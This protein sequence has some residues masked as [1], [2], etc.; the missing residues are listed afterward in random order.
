M[1]KILSLEEL[2]CT[3]CGQGFSYDRKEILNTI[4]DFINEGLCLHDIYC[5]GCGELLTIKFKLDID[6]IPYDESEIDD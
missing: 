4:D 3:E 6:I 1:S 5:D 2:N